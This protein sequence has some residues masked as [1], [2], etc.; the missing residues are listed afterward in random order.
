MSRL[1]RP[2]HSSWN[3]NWSCLIDRFFQ[4]WNW[5]EPWRQSGVTEGTQAVTFPCLQGKS[6]GLG[7]W[8][9]LS[10]CGKVASAWLSYVRSSGAPAPLF[11]R[12]GIYRTSGVHILIPRVM[13]TQG[14]GDEPLIASVPPT[15][16]RGC[17]LRTSFLRQMPQ[18]FC[19]PR[20]YLPRLLFRSIT[21]DI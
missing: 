16:E 13:H 9:R 8:M 11:L 2:D 12:N 6:S 1:L 21:A 17:G 7:V 18:R 14:P 20:G 19:Q 15:R 10:E 3:A 5:R 4:I